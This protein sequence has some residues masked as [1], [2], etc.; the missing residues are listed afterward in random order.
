MTQRTWAAVLAVPLFVA[1]GF[2]LALTGLPFVT[3]A[4]GPSINVLGDSGDK[5]IIGIQGHRVYR[6]DGQ[7]RMTTVS[8]TE[9]NARLD[10]FTLMKT[11]FSKVD[12]VYPFSAQYPSTGSQKEDTHEG[13]VEMQTS[14]ESAVVAALTQ[15]GYH[16]HPQLKIAEVTKGMPADGQLEPGDVLVKVGDTRITADTDVSKLM[17]A[18]PAGGSVPIVVKRGNERVTV[19]LTPVEKDGHRLVGITLA[20]LY[21]FP[22]KVAINIADIG[23]PSAGLMFALSIYDVLTPGSLTDGNAV[24]GTGTIDTRG[25]VGEIGGI[26]QKIAGARR[27]GAQL[28]LVPAGNCADALGAQNGS[29]RLAKATTMKDALAT[30]K[31]WSANHD[32]PLPE[33]TAG[34]GS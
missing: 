14:Q 7:L 1:L 28:F 34:S 11:W 15:L 23:G 13:Q 17:A 20:P 18:V 2:V 29:M 24:A 5:P 19:D 4:P 12:A 32:A 31:A 30:V 10:L 33:C 21:H 22:V 27:D 6:D 3:Y 8:V 16:L 26:Q 9:R 25:N